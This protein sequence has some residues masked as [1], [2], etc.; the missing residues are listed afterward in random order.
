M[1]TVGIDNGVSGAIAILGP[2]GSLID[3][4]PIPVKARASCREIDP[5]AVWDW[6]RDRINDREGV[7]VI[8]EE[9]GGSKSAKAAKSMAGSFHSLRTI[10]ELKGLTYQRI[11]PQ[12]WQKSILGKVPAGETKPRALAAAKALWPEETWL[13]SPRCTTP[14]DGIVDAALI[15]EHGRRSL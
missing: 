6:L 11:T 5:V 9:P 13:A 7:L 8:I 12:S 15:A 14:H 3:A 2:S 4:T 10:C 1:I